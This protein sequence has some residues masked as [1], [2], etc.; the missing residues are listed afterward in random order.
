MGRRV[1]Y[2]SR[3]AAMLAKALTDLQIPPNAV[4]GTQR[5]TAPSTR[6]GA[7][8]S[9][10]ACQHGIPHIV[11]HYQGPRQWADVWRTP[12]VVLPCWQRHSLTSFLAFWQALKG[13]ALS[14]LG[15]ASLTDG[16]SQRLIP[17]MVRHTP[18]W[19]AAQLAGLCH[20]W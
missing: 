5:R 1:R 7:S 6:E 2:T 9:D 3:D 10:G 4:A 20:I 15:G 11:K 8:K 16:G 12:Q 19:R 13:A 18:D 14:T 17:H